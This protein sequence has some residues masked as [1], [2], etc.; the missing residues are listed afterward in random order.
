[1]GES[2]VRCKRGSQERSEAGETGGARGWE[3]GAGVQV[4]A[5]TLEISSRELGSSL[6]RVINAT[7]HQMLSS[8]D[9]L[10]RGVVDSNL[11]ASEGPARVSEL[12]LMMRL[13]GKCV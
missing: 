6:S 8:R 3:A 10:P 13:V 7:R 12:R 2:E 1:M 4:S 11:A 9:G 5:P